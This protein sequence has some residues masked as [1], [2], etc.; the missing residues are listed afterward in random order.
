MKLLLLT[1]V[2]VEVH[3][4][5]LPWLVVLDFNEAGAAARDRYSPLLRQAALAW[6]RLQT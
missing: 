2:I 3:N 5:P 6:N 1:R 4:F